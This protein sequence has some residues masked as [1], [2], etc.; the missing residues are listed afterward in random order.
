[1]IKLIVS[2]LFS[3]STRQLKVWDASSPHLNVSLLVSELWFLSRYGFPVWNSLFDFP[4][5]QSPLCP[6]YSQPRAVKPV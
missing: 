2:A 6:T 4:Q 1:M 3:S 5:S